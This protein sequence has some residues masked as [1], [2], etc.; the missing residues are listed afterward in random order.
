[1]RSPMK[2]SMTALIFHPIYSQLD[3]PPGHRFP[4][5][6]YQGMY[7]KLCAH[8]IKPAQFLRPKALLSEQIK[9]ALCPDYIEQFVTGALDAKAI[10]KIGFPWS[11]HLV[12]RTFTAVAGTVLAGMQSLQCGRAINLTGG[13]HHA[14]YDQGSGFC[15]IND[16]YLSAL[17]L[18]RQSGIER[19]LIFDC[20]VHQGD[21]TAKLAENNP[22]IFT[23]SIHGEKN[24]PFTKQISD[25]DVALP[26][27]VQDDEYLQCV[28]ST[29]IQAINQFQP[30]AI[31]YDAGADIHIN[32]ELGH[33]DISL[34][35]VL[36]R[37]QLVF[38]HGD[39]TGLPISAVTGGGYQ[40]D[41]DALVDV[42]FC[43]F[44]AALG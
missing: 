11:P 25:I 1:M 33:F 24:F 38:Q 29:L 12:K 27:G 10:R 35:G 32:D 16:L 28:D 7:D 43:L 17:N 22:Q 2:P 41:I 30:D 39:R 14:F 8:G 31:I 21:G 9:E 3:L 34:A 40:R 6:K 15:I 26:K 36:Q 20:D 37:D 23:V 13:Y 44:K 4:I 42:H 18:L 19:V 5:G